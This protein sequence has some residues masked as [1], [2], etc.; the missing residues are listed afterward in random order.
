MQISQWVE[1]RISSGDFFYG[2]G[3]FE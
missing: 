1:K 3:V 2:A